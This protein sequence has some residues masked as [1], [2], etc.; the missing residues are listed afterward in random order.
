MDIVV[1]IVMN[2]VMD[3]VMDIVSS[4]KPTR[5]EHSHQA[6]SEQ[7]SISTISPKGKSP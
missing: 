3:I 5:T 6:R 1:D 7:K 2:I 4:V